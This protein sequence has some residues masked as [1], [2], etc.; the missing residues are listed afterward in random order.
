MS[1]FSTVALSTIDK[2]EKH[3]DADSLDIVEVDGCPAIVRRGD[4]KA[5]E[6]VVYIP[7]DM[8]IPGSEDFDEVFRGK[9]VKPVRLRGIF[10]MAVVLKNKWG[11]KEGDDIGAALGIVKWEPSAEK[12]INPKTGV[13]FDEAPPPPGVSVSKYDLE[14]LRKYQGLLTLGEEV[15]ITEK[16]HGTNAKF[17]L[18]DG[19]LYVGSRSHWLKEENGGMYWEVAKQYDLATKLQD[20]PDMVLFGEIYG[21]VQKGYQYGIDKGKFE[22]AAFDA[23][24]ARV[25]RFLHW[26]EFENV[27]GAADIPTTPLLYKGPWLGFQAHEHLAEGASMYGGNIREG[28]VVKPVVERY[29][30]RLGRVSLKLH[31]QGYLLSKRG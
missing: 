16:I 2:L 8:V 26:T 3:P 1:S 18:T 31:G 17:C 24:N 19:K 6:T 28:Y 10:S 4:F 13:P 30:L 12:L 25:N 9:R 22:L 29:E 7:F 11:F 27:M 20:Y 15:V 14:S 21:Q 5:G 23:Y